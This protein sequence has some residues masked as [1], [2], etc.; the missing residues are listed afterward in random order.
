MLERIRRSLMLAALLIVVAPLTGWGQ[1]QTR[2]FSGA[3][4]KV[5]DRRIVVRNRMDDESSFV[6]IEETV[7]TG[8]KAAWHELERN[9][10]VTVPWKFV[11]KPKKA[12]VVRVQP[13]RDSRR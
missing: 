6:R 12:Y 2:E 9:D 4:Q 11:D 13:P 5:D 8:A 7:V 3:I 1:G 10:Q